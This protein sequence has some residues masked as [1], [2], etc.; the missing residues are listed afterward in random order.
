MVR[1]SDGRKTQLRPLFALLGLGAVIT[2]LSA[3]ALSG[4]PPASLWLAGVATVVLNSILIYR[5]GRLSER[6]LS[7]SLP[8]FF[9]GFKQGLMS[10]PDGDGSGA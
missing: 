8:D 2:S 4:P 9:R 3:I 1:L 7:Q 6:S 10:R 5:L